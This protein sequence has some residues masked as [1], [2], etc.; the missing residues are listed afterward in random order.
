MGLYY[1]SQWYN[2]SFRIKAPLGFFTSIGL[3]LKYRKAMNYSFIISHKLYGASE[4]YFKSLGVTD[5]KTKKTK[6]SI[7]MDIYWDTLNNY[8]H[9]LEDPTT[10]KEWYK[11]VQHS[12]YDS[13]ICYNGT[14]F[15]VKKAYAIGINILKSKGA[16][17]GNN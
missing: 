16:S 13:F 7:L 6:F 9:L 10:H 15:D 17:N 3:R 5:T 2:S 1:V 11:K 12:A 4:A 14:A 8:K